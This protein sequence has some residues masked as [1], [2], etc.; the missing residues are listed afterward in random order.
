MA[1]KR[2][3]PTNAE[4]YIIASAPDSS[5]NEGDYIVATAPDASSFWSADINADHPTLGRSIMAGSSGLAK[6]LLGLVGDIPHFA[7][8]ALSGP[9]AAEQV[10]QLSPYV[11]KGVDWLLE[12]AA[13]YKPATKAEADVETVGKYIGAAPLFEA[14]IPALVS[15]TGGGIGDVVAGRMFSDSPT[16]R[17]VGSLIG[18]LTPAAVETAGARF[19]SPFTKTG[20]EKIAGQKLLS[21]L[22]EQQKSRLDDYLAQQANDGTPPPAGDG[23]ASVVRQ[24]TLAEVTQSPETANAQIAF[25]GEKTPE[26]SKYL[27]GQQTRLDAI[28]ADI[29]KL[30]PGSMDSTLTADVRGENLRNAIAPIV[31]DAHQNASN[32]FSIF[33]ESQVTIPVPNLPGKLEGL[34]NEAG[35]LG[36]GPNSSKFMDAVGPGGSYYRPEAEVRAEKAGLILPKSMEVPSNESGLSLG[37][38]QRVRSDAIGQVN[39]LHNASNWKDA[40][41]AKELVDELDSA[42]ENYVT[43]I[44]A[45]RIKADPKT[46]QDIFAAYDAIKNWRKYSNIYRSGLVGELLRT[47]SGNYR[48]GNSAIIKK[49]AATPEASRQFATA[50][51]GRSDVMQQAQA[52][53][54]AD[55]SAKDITGWPQYFQRRRSQFQHIFQDKFDQLES[56][57]G[58][59]ASSNSVKK[60]QGQITKGGSQTAFVSAAKALSDPEA[61]LKLM[62]SRAGSVVSGTVGAYLG[63]GGMGSAT[64]TVIGLTVGQGMANLANQS[65]S[66]V[67]R[68]LLEAYSNPQIAAE[69]MKDATP[70]RL[71]KLMVAIPALGLSQMA[72][73]AMATEG[74]QQTQT[75]QSTSAPNMSFIPT[76]PSEYE[77]PSEGGA[78]NG[79]DVEPSMD[80][81][82]AIIKKAPPLIQAMVKVESGFNPN[83]VGSSGEIG[84]TQLMPAT[85]KALGITNPYDPQ[86]NLEGGQRWFDMMNEKYGYLGDVR[87]VLAA[88]NAGEPA[89]DAA[90]NKARARGEQIIWPNIRKYLKGGAQT[91]PTQVM[92]ALAEIEQESQGL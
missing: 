13:N 37:N 91:Y 19:I 71:F 8:Y 60:L 31:D 41:F 52:G 47:I 69:L 12:H 11:N 63:H 34:I 84:L 83:A 7:T 27:E 21:S 16:A 61:Y 67:R 18:G 25:G 56:F 35:P 17:L 87:I 55:M 45:G 28:R 14:S 81:V 89:V 20:A 88:Y 3:I 1:N 82:S 40:R 26:G 74:N 77:M 76:D 79:G 38:F 10:P 64:G 36:P 44:Q 70:E 33:N 58:E 59:I 75:Q 57:I 51:G 66:N 49:I 24:P 43:G 5:A 62:G 86:Q 92:A 4:D 48:V 2:F 15:A 65:L 85:I 68:A 30:A 72:T 90:I 9:Y 54:I 32:K 46:E 22:T 6:G 73:N 23:G 53:L 42:V 78:A 50:F 80:K 39:D 29:E